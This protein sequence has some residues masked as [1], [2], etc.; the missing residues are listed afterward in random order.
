MAF[1]VLFLF[2]LP[3]L[4]L[5]ASLGEWTKAAPMPSKRTEVAVAELHGKIYVIGGFG[6]FF[7]GGVSDAVEAYDPE[8]DR[9]QKKA[10][11]LESLHHTAVAAVNGKLYVVGGYA[12]IWPWKAVNT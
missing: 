12:R 5:A 7:L 2:G 9:W 4:A 11:L 6:Y 1:V 8:T 3:L 10:P